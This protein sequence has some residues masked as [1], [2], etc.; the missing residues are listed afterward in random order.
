MYV[1]FFRFF[2]ELTSKTRAI[3]FAGI[4]VTL[5]QA[6]NLFAI[7][8]IVQKILNLDFTGYLFSKKIIF[9]LLFLVAAC[10][11]MAI[12]NV[13]GQRIKNTLDERFYKPQLRRYVIITSVAFI[14]GFSLHLLTNTTAQ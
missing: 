9:L 6:L 8:A 10:I 3:V 5:L 11:N 13:V 2:K 1:E 12:C 7:I 14:I 4:I